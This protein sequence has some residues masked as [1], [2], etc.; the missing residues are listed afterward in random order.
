MSSIQ[1]T[2]RVSQLSKLYPTYYGGR[3]EIAQYQSLAT[4]KYLTL[5]MVKPCSH[6]GQHMGL[7]NCFDM[8]D[9]DIHQ[10]GRTQAQL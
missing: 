10:H 9:P 3:Q 2:Y 5:S 1:R 7:I 8:M 4:L 6:P